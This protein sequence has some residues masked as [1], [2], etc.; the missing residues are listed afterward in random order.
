MR[1]Q[2]RH[3]LKR[4]STPWAKG[5]DRAKREKRESGESQDERDSPLLAYMKGWGYL[6]LTGRTEK[7]IQASSFL[8]T[9]MPSPFPLVIMVKMRLQITS[10]S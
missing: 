1:G 2:R 4:L 8:E 6:S 10:F 9:E 7:P 3:G 5:N